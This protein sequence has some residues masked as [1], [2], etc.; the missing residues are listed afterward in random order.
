MGEKKQNQVVARKMCKIQKLKFFV[1]V[2]LD[3]RIF[4]RE[5]AQQIEAEYGWRANTF[6]PPIKVKRSSST[7]L[8]QVCKNHGPHSLTIALRTVAFINKINGCEWAPRTCCRDYGE[9]MHGLAKEFHQS[10]CYFLQKIV[11]LGNL[12]LSC[13]S[14]TEKEDHNPSLVKFLK[15]VGW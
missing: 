14:R 5:G 7:V 4:Q 2:F 3:S 10:I 9:V 1:S 8:I 13:W 6:G 12:N 15:K 11:M